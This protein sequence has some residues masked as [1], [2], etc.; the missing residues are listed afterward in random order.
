MRF[1]FFVHGQGD[2]IYNSTSTSL[3]DFQQLGCSVI[4]SYSQGVTW[5][6]AQPYFLSL[7]FVIFSFR[8]C[9][10]HVILLGSSAMIYEM[11]YASSCNCPAKHI[12]TR[13]HRYLEG[14][15]HTGHLFQVTSR[16]M[17]LLFANIDISVKN[18]GEAKT[19]LLAAVVSQS[20]TIVQ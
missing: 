10:S 20:E 8:L 6:C 1:F 5:R 19:I 16:L 17:P 15:H 3:Q 12:G 14:R 7:L 11:I 4:G 9:R 2:G 18:L 13:Y